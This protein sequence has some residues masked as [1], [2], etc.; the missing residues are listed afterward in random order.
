M[1]SK[2]CSSI[3][4]NFRLPRI[5]FPKKYATKRCSWWGILRAISSER[6]SAARFGSPVEQSGQLGLRLVSVGC[7]QAKLT[8]S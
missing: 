4:A 1:I 3:R 5:V 8:A 6:P 2:P 7:N